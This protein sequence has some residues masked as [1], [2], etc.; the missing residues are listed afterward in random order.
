[1]V[2][3]RKVTYNP[4]NQRIRITHLKPFHIKNL[5]KTQPLFKNLKLGCPNYIS[6][7]QTQKYA[8]HRKII[9]KNKRTIDKKFQFF[10]LI[11]KSNT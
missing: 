7:D 11:G 8:N 3:Q 6:G 4:P 10:S 9:T 1:M 2:K 5:N